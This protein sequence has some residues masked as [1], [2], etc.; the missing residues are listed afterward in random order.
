MTALPPDQ[1]YNVLRRMPKVNKHLTDVERAAL[2]T[3]VQHYDQQPPRPAMK[4]PRDEIDL[5][6]LK[7]QLVISRATVRSLRKA[8]AE[9]DESLGL[10]G[11]ARHSS[12]EAGG[13]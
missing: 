11:A 9:R 4:R 6:Q 12:L 8:L 2:E 5:E 10:L 13:R 7:S 3:A 1:A